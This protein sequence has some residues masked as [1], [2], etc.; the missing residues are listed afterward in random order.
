MLVEIQIECPHCG[1]SNDRHA[2]TS[3]GD[4]ETIDDCTVCCR[5]FN[6]VVKSSEPGRVDEAYATLTA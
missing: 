3:E 5:P 6:L 4:Y 1:E 2:D